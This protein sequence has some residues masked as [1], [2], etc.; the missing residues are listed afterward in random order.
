MFDLTIVPAC[1]CLCVCELLVVLVFICNH[2]PF[3]V[4]LK[5]EDFSLRSVVFS[6]QVCLV[7]SCCVERL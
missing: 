1:F 6:W 5:G 4:M 2:C 3:V 7:P